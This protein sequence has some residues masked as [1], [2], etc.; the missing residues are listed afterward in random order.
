M[1]TGWVRASAPA[2]LF[3]AAIGAPL[4]AVA[5]RLP[6][7]LGPATLVA[8]PVALLVLVLS[9]RD[10]RWAIALFGASLPGGLATVV[11]GVQLVQVVAV[12]SIGLVGLARV[13]RGQRPL[14]LPPVVIALLALVAWSLIT[15]SVV[16]DLA[17][18]LR[19][20]AALLTAT[21]LVAAVVSATNASVTRL[22]HIALLLFAGSVATCAIA[23]PESTQR[24]SFGAAIVDGRA[25]GVFNQPNELGL[26]AGTT[27]ILA[28]ALLV[29][30][31][32]SRHPRAE[33]LL[34]GLGGSVALVALLL[35]LSRGAW[36]GTL[37]ALT[38]GTVFVSAIRRVVLVGVAAAALITAVMVST[39]STPS[40]LLVIVARA[41]LMTDRGANPYDERP[42]IW[43]EGV[44]QVHDH[45][46]T[47][48]GAAGFTDAS[49]RS[50]S[51]VVAAVR[52]AHAH[53]VVL[54]FAAEG[55]LPAGFALLAATALTGAA[56]LRGRGRPGWSGG[57]RA[58][59]TTVGCVPLVIL[60]QG[61]L[62]APLRNPTTLLH[63]SAVLGLAVA[64]G[65]VRPAPEPEVHEGSVLQRRAELC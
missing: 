63:T 9:V 42:A 2:L 49:V 45:P 64:V 59:L 20:T 47:G 46:W 16:D 62:D 58:F 1:S 29:S 52:P 54:N 57:E 13:V 60:G 41:G 12:G 22:R 30:S 48:V 38:V 21:L 31:P 32:V 27:V 40:Q 55:G 35:S 25:Q 37:L 23:L 26:F 65:Y 7:Q 3:G 33:R 43:S 4:A 11:G 10:E 28:L 53:N 36:L 17:R 6:G 56:V 5:L 8:A 50:N 14:A 15:M 34:V 19:W 61:L 18:A 44:R 24:R 39:G 51:E